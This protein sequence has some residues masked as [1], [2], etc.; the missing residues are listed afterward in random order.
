MDI[1]MGD[2]RQELSFSGVHMCVCVYVCVCVKEDNDT[3]L[4]PGIF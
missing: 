2:L 3:N 1:G 4:D